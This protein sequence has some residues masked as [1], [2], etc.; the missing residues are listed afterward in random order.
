MQK[1]L[2]TLYVVQLSFFNA[3]FTYSVCIV[4]ALY[5]FPLWTMFSALEYPIQHTHTQTDMNSSSQLK[6]DDNRTG[7]MVNCFAVCSSNGASSSI[8]I[9]VSVFRFKQGLGRSNSVGAGAN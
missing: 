7:G 3:S 8:R 6:L 9:D 4:V 5:M 1:V 2:A